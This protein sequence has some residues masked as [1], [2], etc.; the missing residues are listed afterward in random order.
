MFR[1]TP[2]SDGH[3]ETYRRHIGEVTGKQDSTLIASPESYGS[4]EY[5][6]GIVRAVMEATKK[7]A[8]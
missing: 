7:R 4:F 1:T 5:E 2:S 6:P 8:A 3:F